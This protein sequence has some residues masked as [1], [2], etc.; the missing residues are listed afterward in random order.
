MALPFVLGSGLLRL[1]LTQLTVRGFLA[2]AVV[3]LFCPGL[4]EELVFRVWLLPHPAERRSSRFRLAWTVAAVTLFTLWHPLNAW[5]LLPEARRIFWDWRFLVVVVLLGAAC[6]LAYLRTGSI[7][8]PIA[9]HWL[10]VV[11]WKTLLTGP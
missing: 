3:M 1:D 9:V 7:Y 10:T 11:A 8:A 6:S 2:A 5:L 4:L